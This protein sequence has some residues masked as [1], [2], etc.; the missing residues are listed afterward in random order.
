MRAEEIKGLMEAYS[1]I[2]ETP[3]VLN[4]E[5]VEEDLEQLMERG[6]PTDPKARAAYDAQVA[7]NRAAL[8]NTL[9]FGNPQGRKPAT[10]STPTNV[11]G[12]R[13]TPSTS[14]AKPTQSKFAGA[15]DAAFAKAAQIKGSPV[16]GPK[17]AAAP[18]AAKPAAPAAAKPVAKPAAA[19]AP[20]PAEAPK[21]TFN[22]LMQKTFGYQTGYAPDQVKGNIKKMAQM[23]SLK[24]ISAGVDIFDLV[25][26]HL[27][28][29]G[30]ADSEEG[31]MVIMVNMSEEWKNSIL[32]SYGIELDEASYSAK[33]ARAGKDI[34]KPGKMFG[35]IAKEAGERY[36]SEERGKKVAGAV[37]AKLRKEEV[38]EIDEVQ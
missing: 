29:E 30:Y 3:E 32:E 8:G 18:A 5:V 33:A 12:S 25:K 35:K 15:R 7:K 13:P 2:H 21:K 38:V 23:A 20:K 10:L 22:P 1:K 24:N 17:P 6:A 37:L 19:P 31:A 9:L 26:G 34:G 4:E 36:G 14:A 27:L 11:R 16:V 28:D